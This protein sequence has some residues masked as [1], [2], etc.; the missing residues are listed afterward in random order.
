[1]GHSPHQHSG[2]PNPNDG[3][4]FK[5][6]KA[7]LWELIE[8]MHRSH[9]P[10]PLFMFL[11]GASASAAVVMFAVLWFGTPGVPQPP[12]NAIAPDVGIDRGAQNEA[13]VESGKGVADGQEN[14]TVHS[15]AAPR[16]YARP[17]L[18]TRWGS[19]E[20]QEPGYSKVD[21]YHNSPQD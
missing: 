13:P 10:P 20:E 3:D 4:W 5:Q 15:D 12:R 11:L 7:F 21:E 17:E 18:G 1:M 14:L 19:V 9:R 16:S 2:S 8:M 6:I